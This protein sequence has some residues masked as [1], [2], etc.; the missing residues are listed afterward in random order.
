MSCGKN[1][2]TVLK[3]KSFF[4]KPQVHFGIQGVLLMDTKKHH[5][6][7]REPSLRKT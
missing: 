4:T 7:P 6:N 1:P 5:Q 2:E 3:N